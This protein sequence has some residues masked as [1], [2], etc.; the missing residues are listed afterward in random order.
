MKMFTKAQMEK[1]VELENTNRRLKAELQDVKKK[2]QEGDD[3]GSQ[4]RECLRM[5]LFGKTGSGKS[6]TGN[7]IL[8]KEYFKSTVSPKS[9][10]KFCEK[11]TVK[12]DGR[13]VA[14]V[15]TPGLFDTTLSNDEVQEELM[16]C[17]SMSSPGPHVFLLVL[18]IGRFTQEEKDTVELIKKRDDLKGQ[19]IESF[20]QSDDHLE[21]LIN[22]CGGRYQVFNNNQT[23]RRQ[24]RELME[25]TNKML[26]ENGGGCF[27]SEMFQEAE[28]P[29]RRKWRRS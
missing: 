2:S 1:V 8:G 12:I 6:A 9:V 16:K 11:R 23:D 3:D 4:N 10:T 14:V 22:D 25:K 18:Q 21:K 20:I 5:V 17:I 24:V 29:Y 7:T 19:T 13:S 15:D 26:K 28:G 27:T